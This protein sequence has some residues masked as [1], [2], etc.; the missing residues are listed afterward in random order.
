M[1]TGSIPLVIAEVEAFGGAERSLLAL[2]KWL[3][4]H[5]HRNHVLT[6]RDAVGLS[7]YADSSLRVME[8]RPGAGIGAKIAALRKALRGGPPPIVSGYQPAL[9]CTL[10]GVRG[11]HTLMHDTPSLFGDAVG[12]SLPHRLRIALSNKLIGHGLRSGGVT[13]VNSTYLQAECRREFNMHAEIVRMG[14]L[15]SPAPVRARRVEGTL[16]MLSVC[17]IEPNKRIDWILRAL[18][19]LHRE[20]MQGVVDWHLDVAGKGSQLAELTALAA[21][22]GLAEHVTFHGFVPDTTLEDLYQGAHLFLMPAVQGYGIPAL[23]ALQRSLPVL[24]HRESGVSDLLLE[25]PWATVME[26]GEVRMVPALQA[27]M[28]SVA[29][30]R[31]CGVPLPAL[32][33]EE[34][35]AEG[36][37]SLFGYASRG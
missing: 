3:S 15:P 21:E 7:S 37:A 22:L 17:R 11:F 2:A 36:V 20:G 18:S 6:Y 33:T 8:M 31:Q 27:A 13:T 14:G 32:P 25:T 16:R 19:H 29:A 5:G 24:L 23:E 30:C 12:R 9:H 1:E 26:G 35:W 4:Q 10:A 34:S 28:A